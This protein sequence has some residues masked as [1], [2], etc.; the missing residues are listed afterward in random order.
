MGYVRS[1]KFCCC[2]PVRFGVFC[3]SLLGIAIGGLFAVVGWIT[4]HQIL[5]GS[6]SPPYSSGEETAVWA[7]AVISTLISLISLLG[8]VGSLFKILPLVGL[9][10]GAIAAATAVDIAVGIYVIFQLYHGEGASDVNKCVA[11]AGDGVNADFAH[12]ACSGSFKVGRV[13]VV[14]LYVL[15]WL[16]TIYG[17]H[18]AFQY[19]GQLRE[20]R[21]EPAPPA[22]DF[23]KNSQVQNINVVAA[24]A[25]QYPFSTAP[26]AMGT[27]Y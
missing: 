11:N 17:C 1:R 22:S 20:E 16:V 27:R 4:V 2:L 18:I 9:Y 8:L 24:P 25:S 3:E 23:E 14:V 15:F 13:I 12:W 7:L 26:N 10:A 19:V 5:Q 6:V 21:D